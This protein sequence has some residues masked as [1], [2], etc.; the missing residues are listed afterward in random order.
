MVVGREKRLGPYKNLARTLG[1]RERISFFGPQLEVKPFFGCADVFVLPTIYDPFPNAALEALACG[2]PVI[3]TTKSGAAE[4]VEDHDAGFVCTS[5]DVAAL[6]A[7]MRTL[8]DAETRKRQG[9]NARRAVESLTPSAMTLKLVLLYKELL[10]E[11][12]KH[13]TGPRPPHAAPPTT[14]S[15][16][17]KPPQE[18]PLLHGETGLANETLPAAPAPDGK[19]PLL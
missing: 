11:S 3:T 2:L 18:A 17:T 16:A 12:I 7:H 5:R 9:A 13:K 8:L 4:L 14:S 1:V 6:A 10:E 15:L 19:P